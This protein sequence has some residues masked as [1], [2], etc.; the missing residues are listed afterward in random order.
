MEALWWLEQYWFDL[1]QTLGIVGGLFFT[2]YTIWKEERTRQ[3]SNLIA[4]KGEYREIW[5]EVYLRPELSRVFDRNVDLHNKPIST[6][7]QLFVKLLIL[8]LDTVHRMMKSK[9]FVTL[10]GL[11]TDVKE[12]FAAPIPRAIWE[13]LKPLQ[14]DDFVEFIER[15]LQRN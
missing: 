12:F 7:E 5:K 3:I 6:E 2:A 10:K 9:M 14:D 15:N 1:L 11:R 13:K 8:H 4:I